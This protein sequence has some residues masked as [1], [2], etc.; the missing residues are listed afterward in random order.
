[1]EVTWAS[2]TVLAVR[3]TDRIQTTSTL[4]KVETPA[5]FVVTELLSRVDDKGWIEYVRNGKIIMKFRGINEEI[6][7]E[8]MENNCFFLV[9]GIICYLSFLFIFHFYFSIFSRSFLVLFFIFTH[10]L[11]SFS[12]FSCF[13][14]IFFSFRFLLPMTFT[15]S[16]SPRALTTTT[17]PFAVSLTGLA[18]NLLLVSGKLCSLLHMSQRLRHCTWKEVELKENEGN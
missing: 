16:I 5:E 14:H 10:I 18:F 3:W 2:E 15:F 12:S 7:K 4:Y 11:Y 13:S 1:M 8:L 6:D 9:N 17:W